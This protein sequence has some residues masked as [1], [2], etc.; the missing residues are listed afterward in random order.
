M[1]S[2]EKYTGDVRLLKTS[3]SEVYYLAMDNNPE[4]IS[5]ETFE[6][7]QIEKGEEE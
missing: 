4:I 3:K 1:L 2:N 5:K 6:A 7:M